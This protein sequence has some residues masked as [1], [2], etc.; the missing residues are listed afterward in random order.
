MIEKSFV[1]HSVF[2]L[3]CKRGKVSLSL[4]CLL[5]PRPFLLHSPRKPEKKRTREISH[6]LGVCINSHFLIFHSSARE[7]SFTSSD[8]GQPVNESGGHV[9]SL[10]SF[11]NNDVHLVCGLHIGEPQFT[12]VRNSCHSL[13]YW[14]LLWLLF[15]SSQVWGL[16]P[17]IRGA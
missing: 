16:C 13:D 2:A 5:L 9:T 4:R 1:F 11:G 15:P 7:Y 14:Q 17:S 3:T 8:R 6:V 12:S 10:L